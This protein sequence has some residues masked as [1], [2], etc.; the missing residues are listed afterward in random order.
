M[1]QMILSIQEATSFQSDMYEIDQ[2]WVTRF[3]MRV[4]EATVSMTVHLGSTSISIE[5][6]WN[7]SPGDV[8]VLEQGVS[9]PLLATIEGTP[10][11]MGFGVKSNGM[12]HFRVE[13]ILLPPE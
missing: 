8:V 11:F 3:C 10:K 9:Q 13:S 4:Q 5:D 1:D 7:F 12:Q 2:G 6:L